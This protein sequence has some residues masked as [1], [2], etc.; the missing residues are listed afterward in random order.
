MSAGNQ[1]VWIIEM[2]RK[3]MGFGFTPD[4]RRFYASKERVQEIVAGRNHRYR[5]CDHRAVE[6]VRKEPEHAETHSSRD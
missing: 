2:R 5:N 3:D 4:G 6:Y 1:S